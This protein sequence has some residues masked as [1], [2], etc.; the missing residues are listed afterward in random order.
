MTQVKLASLDVMAPRAVTGRP[1]KDGAA[2][3][4]VAGAPG[5]PGTSIDTAIVNGDGN[6]LLG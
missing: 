4:G 6:L 2:G 1:G 3:V 5:A